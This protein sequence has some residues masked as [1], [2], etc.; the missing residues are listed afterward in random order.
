MRQRTV[1]PAI[2]TP[3]QPASAGQQAA[4]APNR[5]RRGEPDMGDPRANRVLGALSED[6]YQRWLPHLEAV[7]L[8]LGMVLWNSG[9]PL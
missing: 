5:L 3:T 9:Q 1:M 2:L 6:T 8:P 7:D 4:R